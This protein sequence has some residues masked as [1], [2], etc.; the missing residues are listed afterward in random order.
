MGADFEWGEMILKY[1][2]KMEIKK[3]YLGKYLHDIAIEQIADDYAQKG[4]TV[5]KEERLGNYQADLIV[6]KGNEQIVIE[7]KTGKMTPEKRQ[8]IADIADH[9]RNLGD[10]KFHVVVA[11][12]PK[13]K[14]L[15][16][17]DLELLINNYI[18][19]NLPSELDELSTHTR[20]DE[21]FDIN[22]E[23][24]NISGKDIF[25][26]GDGVISMELQSGSDGDQDKGD[27][28]TFDKFPFDFEFILTYNSNKEL[29]ITKVEKFKID[30]SDI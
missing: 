30:T 29:E 25:V 24:I 16:I 21:V 6:K 23:K 10:C 19:N 1:R 26:K 28:K 15:G 12:P 22:I 9:V 4:Y 27:F 11:T 8:R 2:V 14:R 17:E 3:E 5:K 7:V 20:P 18:H 13:E